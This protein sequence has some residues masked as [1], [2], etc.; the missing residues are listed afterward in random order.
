MCVKC[1]GAHNEDACP[2]SRQGGSKYLKC[3]FCSGSHPS[4]YVNCKTREEE[5]AVYKSKQAAVTERKKKLNDGVLTTMERLHKQVEP[6]TKVVSCNCHQTAM[7]SSVV[8]QW[9]QLSPTSNVVE[10]QLPGPTLDEVAFATF[11][12]SWK[13]I[14]LAVWRFETE[15]HNT[16]FDKRRELMVQV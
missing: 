14:V 15:F 13:T 2:A 3:H 9:Q 10:D 5:I 11:G 16:P 8:P 12:K 4:N 7:T 1:C 6:Q